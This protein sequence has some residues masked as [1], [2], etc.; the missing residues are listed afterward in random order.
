MAAL[1]PGA[2]APEFSLPNAHGDVHSVA[3]GLAKGPVLLVF[4]KVSCPTC[5]YGLPFFGRLHKRLGEAPLSV[6][7]ISQNSL[8]HT[9]AFAREFGVE[10]LPTLFDPE[11]EGFAVSDLYGITHVPTAFLI[12]Q[13]GKIATTSVGWS[14][15]DT[16][17]IAQR[18]G[19]AAGK[20]GL[21]LFEADEK[22]VDF[23]PG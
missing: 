10:A 2:A 5:Q 21:A 18:L 22:V 1:E 13:D 16:A 6:W 3:E 20:P 23:R 12:E 14:K 17:A 8:A 7:S 11:D 4:F 19:E 15:D 9:S